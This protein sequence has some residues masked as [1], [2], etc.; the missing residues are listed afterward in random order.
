MIRMFHAPFL[1][2]NMVQKQHPLRQ[3]KTVSPIRTVF[4]SS[5]EA[6]GLEDFA[7]AFEHNEA[8]GL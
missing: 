3:R 6:P 4:L 1:L 2:W 7:D 8:L 5:S